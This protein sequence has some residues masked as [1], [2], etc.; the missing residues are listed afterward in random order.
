MEN[1]SKIRH[2]RICLPEIWPSICVWSLI[3]H[4]NGQTV[5]HC[6][7][8]LIMKMKL[9]LISVILIV[10]KVL[11]SVVLIKCIINL[12][13]QYFQRYI[14]PLYIGNI[15]LKSICILK[16]LCIKVELPQNKTQDMM[17]WV[18]NKKC[19]AMGQHS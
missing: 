8:I 1:D 11:I 3:D 2:S 19:H 4:N 12:F 15:W 14:L 10:A 13:K 16:M 5:C 6:L 17:D 7:Y 9:I 18:E